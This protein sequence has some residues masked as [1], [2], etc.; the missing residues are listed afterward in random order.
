MV[1]YGVFIVVVDVD[2][3]TCRAV[4]VDRT[5]L[6][7][8]HISGGEAQLVRIGIAGRAGVRRGVKLDSFRPCISV[9]KAFR[10]FYLPT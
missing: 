6:T 2:L 5:T 3:E 9:R 1:R 10:S 8:L 7:I 4:I